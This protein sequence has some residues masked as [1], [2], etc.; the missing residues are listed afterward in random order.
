MTEFCDIRKRYKARKRIW[1]TAGNV[2]YF[3]IR[4]NT[5]L[6]N[7]AEFYDTFIPYLQFVT[8]NLY[9]TKLED[10]HIEMQDVGRRLINRLL[11]NQ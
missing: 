9:A 6:N 10:N 7:V 2:R 4:I 8:S 11:Q 5:S 1:E 3:V